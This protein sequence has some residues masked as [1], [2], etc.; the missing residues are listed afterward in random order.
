VALSDPLPRDPFARVDYIERG[1]PRYC[2][3]CAD[4]VDGLH[5]YWR[6]CD[7]EGEAPIIVLHPQCARALCVR[8]MRDVWEWEDRANVDAPTP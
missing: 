4:R 3:Y 8:M 2:F 7:P 1:L 5:I 6:G